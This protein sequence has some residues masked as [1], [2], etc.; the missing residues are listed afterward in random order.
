VEKLQKK[1][2]DGKFKTFYKAL[3]TVWSQSKIEK[4]EG[5]LA[6]YQTQMNSILIFLMR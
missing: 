6:R 1:R 5:N 4:F 2:A 3:R